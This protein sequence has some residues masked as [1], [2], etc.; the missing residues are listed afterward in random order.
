MPELRAEAQGVVEG[1]SGGTS[2]LGQEEV[3]W[4]IQ[5]RKAGARSALLQSPSLT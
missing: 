3:V 4:V 1:T 5:E 2:S